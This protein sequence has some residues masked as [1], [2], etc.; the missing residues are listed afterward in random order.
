[1]KNKAITYEEEYE[2]LKTDLLNVS[3]KMEKLETDTLTHKK[4]TEINHK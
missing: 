2:K 4:S 3:E 1:M